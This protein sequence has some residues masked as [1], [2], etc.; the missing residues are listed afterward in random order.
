MDATQQ[1]DVFFLRSDQVAP[2]SRP[3]KPGQAKP[4]S[5]MEATAHPA[6]RGAALPT[7]TTPTTADRSR[8]QNV[9]YVKF[10]VYNNFIPIGFAYY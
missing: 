1:V 7:P 8:D 10:S 3:D 6:A 5:T 2:R 9:S 4:T